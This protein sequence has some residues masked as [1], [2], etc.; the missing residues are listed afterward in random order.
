MKTSRTSP[1]GNENPFLG[2]RL[3]FAAA[4]ERTTEAPYAACKNRG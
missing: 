2:R 3:F 1:D 4:E